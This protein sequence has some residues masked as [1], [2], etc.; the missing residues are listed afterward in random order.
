M[1][2]HDPAQVDDCQHRERAGNNFS[3][4]GGFDYRLTLS[5]S[6]RICFTLRLLPSPP[7]QPPPQLLEAAWFGSFDKHSNT[8]NAEDFFGKVRSSI[9]NLLFLLRSRSLIPRDADK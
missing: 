5:F 2:V 1:N 9:L 7:S 3:Q 4:K 6:N 8:I